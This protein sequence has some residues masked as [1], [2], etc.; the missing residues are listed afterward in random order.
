MPA[1]PRHAGAGPPGAGRGGVA[2]PGPCRPTS[3]AR[4][5]TP[6]PS[7]PIAQGRQ[8]QR[9][10][11]QPQRQAER[12]HGL[13]HRDHPCDMPADPQ[14]GKTDPMQPLDLDHRHR[15]LEEPGRDPDGQRGPDEIGQ[16]R[17]PRHLRRRSR[18]DRSVFEPPRRPGRRPAQG[19]TECRRGEVGTRYVRD[20]AR[21]RVR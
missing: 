3:R 15:Q 4:M 1:P 6:T 11:H 18:L 7:A 17:G 14:R 10:R 2:S 9:R 21:L 16:P 20:G 13:R 19:T 5:P 12:H 8:R